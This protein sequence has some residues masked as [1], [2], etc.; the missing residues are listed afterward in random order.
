MN[1]QMFHT[2]NGFEIVGDMIR[3]HDVVGGGRYY[4]GGKELR[5]LLDTLIPEST[6][7]GHDNMG[8]VRVTVN[9]LNE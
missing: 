4:V 3:L 1:V 5:T 9:K 2:G 7:Y 8:R 6:D